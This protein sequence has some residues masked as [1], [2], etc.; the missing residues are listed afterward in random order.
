MEQ[1]ETHFRK[2]DKTSTVAPAKM[3]DVAVAYSE[4]AVAGT[5]KSRAYPVILEQRQ[6]FATIQKNR[7]AG[8]VSIIG[9]VGAVALRII[10]RSHVR[11]YDA[12][13][14]LLADPTND[15]PT[16]CPSAVMGP[17]G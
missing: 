16:P 5:P 2:G 12:P 15:K 11:M 17:N 13:K 7:G 4:R 9:L 8:R 6:P 10:I 3:P 1:N 14:K